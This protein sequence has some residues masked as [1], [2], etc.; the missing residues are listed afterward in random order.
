MIQP[1]KLMLVRPRLQ[2][3]AYAQDNYIQPHHGV[4]A[5][6]C[7]RQKIS[8]RAHYSTMFTALLYFLPI[9]GTQ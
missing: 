3:I 1:Q 4:Q 9:G 7:M 8:P 2:D 5:T 6:M